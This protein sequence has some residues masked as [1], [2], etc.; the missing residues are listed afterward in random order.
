MAIRVV[1]MV[2]RL[3]DAPGQGI[4][5]VLCNIALLGF[6]AHGK[7]SIASWGRSAGI[8]I[9]VVVQSL[10]IREPAHPGGERSTTAMSV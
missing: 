7:G 3:T 5:V 6:Y 9:G 10:E 1:A 4:W 2:V 8:A